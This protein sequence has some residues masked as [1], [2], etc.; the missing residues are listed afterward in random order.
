VLSIMALSR[1]TVATAA[2]ARVYYICIA[3][4]E[5]LTLLIKDLLLL[6]LS[7]GLYFAWSGKPVWQFI[8]NVD[9]LW[10]CNFTS[11]MYCIIE[12]AA[13]TAVLAL[14]VER[15]I[16]LYYPFEAR[17]LITKTKTIVGLVLQFLFGAVLYLFVF[18]H[19]K[20]YYIHGSLASCE[21]DISQLYLEVLSFLC[22]SIG[23][24]PPLM[25]TVLC[26]A[27]AL[28]VKWLIS[29]QRCATDATRRKDLKSVAV[30]LLTVFL[31]DLTFVPLAI[32]Y[33]STFIARLLYTNEAEWTLRFSAIAGL[34]F[35]FRAVNSVLNFP[36]YW[37][38]LPAFRATV[39]NQLRCLS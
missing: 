39:R 2:T 24:M 26:V 8:V 18:L 5:T 16:V 14:C 35:T 15:L 33:G 30:V 3:F 29:G 34:F 1:R 21:A 7:P 4:Y 17:R 20:V 12:F 27:I 19:S 37:F 22:L 32:M 10:S 23:A 13:E 36:I 38:K 6:T 11:Y 31:S 25:S 9:P 28:K